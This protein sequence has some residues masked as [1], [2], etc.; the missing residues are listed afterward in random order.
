MA[1]GRY[2]TQQDVEFF[3]DLHKQYPKASPTELEEIATR[4]ST[5]IARILAGDY[6]DVDSPTPISYAQ[7][8]LFDHQD[9]DVLE[10]ILAVLRRIESKL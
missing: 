10:S 4:S 8:S 9:D 6:D 7:G 2:V 5:T 3:K 1:R